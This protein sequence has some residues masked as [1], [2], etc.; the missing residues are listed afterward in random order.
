M[1][2]EFE[3]EEGM[4]VEDFDAVYHLDPEGDVY[5]YPTKFVWRSPRLPT[6]LKVFGEPRPFRVVRVWAFVSNTQKNESY[7]WARAAEIPLSD[8]EGARQA[9]LG[10]Y[11]ALVAELDE[12]AYMMAR[13]LFGWTAYT[14]GTRAPTGLGG[15]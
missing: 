9:A 14:L 13:R 1:T 5:H 3:A 7:L 11:E 12:H 6:G 10:L 15:V 2:A 8:F 4:E